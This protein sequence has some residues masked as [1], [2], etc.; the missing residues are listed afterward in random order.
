MRIRMRGK[1]E[2]VFDT[3]ITEGAKGVPVILLG[4]IA[5]PADQVDGLGVGLEVVE[6][7]AAELAALQAGGFGRLPGVQELLKDTGEPHSDL[8]AGEV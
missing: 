4:C 6:A 8:A 5:I 7:D 3:A 1:T 2:R